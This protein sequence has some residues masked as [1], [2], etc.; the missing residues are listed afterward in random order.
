MFLE[1]GEMIQGWEI[2]MG[3]LKN[4]VQK[5]GHFRQ[6]ILVRIKLNVKQ[7]EKQLSVKIDEK[8]EDQY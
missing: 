7:K 3:N 6:V 8:L 1:K 5:Q 4:N 2:I